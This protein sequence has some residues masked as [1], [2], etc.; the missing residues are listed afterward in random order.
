VGLTDMMAQYEQLDIALD[1][2]PYNGG[3]TTLQAMWM[4]VPVLCKQGDYFTSRMSASFMCRAGLDDWVAQTD[5]DYV[6]IAIEKAQDRRALLALK[7][8]L[9]NRQL[10][11]PA[12]DAVLHT[13]SFEQCLV[14]I[15]SATA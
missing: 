1:P 5:A 2:I 12:W 4:G 14:Q 9:R 7:Q 13:R 6:R 15:T 8:G 11:I 3:T 10:A